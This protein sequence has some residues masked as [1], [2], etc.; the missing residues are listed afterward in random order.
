[1]YCDVN[2]IPSLTILE[3]NWLTVR[4][5]LEALDPA[6]FRPWVERIYT[7]DGWKVFPLF[8]FGRR[9]EE[10]CQ[11]CPETTRLLE[12]LPGMVAAGFS[13]LAA[14]SRILPHC[15]YKGYSDYHLRAHLALVIPASGACGLTV[16]GETRGWY[17]GKC[18]LFNDSTEHNAWNDGPGDRV[19]LLVDLQN[20]TLPEE[21]RRHWSVT[22]ELLS[23]LAG[24]LGINPFG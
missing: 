11:R 13:R 3:E 18:L 6:S 8:V 24:L 20:P 17:E 12:S 1:M 15:G 4:R 5:E 21:Q 16:G 2:L 7:N 22:P 10:N 14:A 9:N 19:V 23:E